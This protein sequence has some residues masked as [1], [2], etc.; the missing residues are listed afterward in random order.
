MQKK[1]FHLSSYSKVEH[2]KDKNDGEYENSIDVG[3]V[4]GATK[5]PNDG[6]APDE[7]G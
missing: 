7:D 1:L 5:S 2:L 6:E 3:D 4:E